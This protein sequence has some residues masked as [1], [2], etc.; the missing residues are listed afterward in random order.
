MNNIDPKHHN[1]SD[2]D[3]LEAPELAPINAQVAPKKHGLLTFM[4]DFGPLLVFF[5]TFKYFS[6]DSA[7]FF[8]PFDYFSKFEKS[9]QGPLIGTAIFMVAIIIAM[10]VA[11]VKLG[12]ISPMMWLS[13]V[14]V[15]GFG[16]LTLYFNDP[17]FLQV[18]PTIIY[19]FFALLLIG[20]Y[21][22]GKAML[23]YLL[24]AAF[25][26][27]SDEGWLKLSRNWGLFFVVM[28]I[29]NELIWRNFSFDTWTTI[30]V[31]G[32]TAASFIMTF[33]NVPMLLKHGLNLGI[34]EDDEVNRHK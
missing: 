12:K 31:F 29:A 15:I 22:R 23:R 1:D 20:G 7:V 11:K 26:G 33:A 32:F 10:I 16:A 19:S 27:V 30:K 13:S 28:A 6:S 14:L 4:L 24:E 5:G 18:K 9:L 17:I 8:G 3:A 34:E 2:K 21:L 25:E